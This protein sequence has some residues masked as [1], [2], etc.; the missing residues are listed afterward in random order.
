MNECMVLAQHLDFT[1]KRTKIIAMKTLA[2][3]WVALSSI[4]TMH[5]QDKWEDYIIGKPMPGY[6]EAKKLT[7]KQWGLNYKAL[8]A[9][10]VF[11]DEMR[12]KQQSLK[13]SNTRY[14]KKIAKKWGADWQQ[15]FNL[16]VRKEMNRTVYAS[17]TAVW[18]D[19]VQGKPYMAYFEAKEAIAK[20]WG[21]NYKA[22][23]LGCDISQSPD[24]TLRDKVEKS[25]QYLTRLNARLGDD[26]QK[27]LEEEVQ[28]A[29]KQ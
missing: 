13:K 18:V 21:I 28:L 2:L 25:A 19:I 22:V 4:C 6:V 12:Q 16:D 17:D 1:N 20:K 29:L 7:A 3:L 9:G 11:T 15:K 5:A 27:H 10:C 14:F 8:F 26:W 23:F 24:K